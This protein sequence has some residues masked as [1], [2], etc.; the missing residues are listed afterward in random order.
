MAAWIIVLAGLT[1]F[2]GDLERDKENPNREISGNIVNSSAEVILQRNRWG[3]YLVDGTIN[4]QPVTFMVDTGATTVAIPYHM[5]ERLNLRSGPAYSVQTANGN[6]TAYGSDIAD[7]AIGTLRFSG[8]RA[9]L[10]VGMEGEEVLLGMSALRDLELI[11]RDGQL[12]MR[13]YLGQ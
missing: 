1:W 6:T 13:Q 8:V 7:M 12:I 10:T 5:R 2:F 9:G 3:H 4:G 11:Q